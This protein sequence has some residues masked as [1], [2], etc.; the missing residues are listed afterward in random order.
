MNQNVEP[1]IYQYRSAKDYLVDVV[2]AKQRADQNFSI[3]GWAREMGMP[4]HSLLVMVLQ[5]KRKVSIK[6]IPF[7][8]RGLNLTKND[9]LYFQAIIQFENAT[10]PA[11]QSMYANWLSENSPKDSTSI[12]V[13]DQF[14]MISEWI[15]MAIM[16][17]VSLRNF[18][19]TVAYIQKR[20]RKKFTTQEISSAIKRL[21]QFKLLEEVEGK[22]YLTAT[23]STT[24]ND[25]ADAGVRDYHKQVAELAKEA[26]EEQ[27]SAEREFQSFTVPVASDQIMVAKKMI[28]EF[29][30]ELCRVLTAKPGDEVYQVNLH[31]FS[32]T[33]TEEELNE[34]PK[35][36][37][38]GSRS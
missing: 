18:D 20:L 2:A 32:L 1:E 36:L 35:I 28:R 14:W 4:S 33:R 9:Q 6:Q 19:H 7:F 24:R 25:I 34:M 27:S 5:G 31:F 13:I 22:L 3:R 30:T 16:A 21:R 38:K 37:K 10:T 12:N 17:M 26:V 23:V 15:H 8:A 29:R 11:E